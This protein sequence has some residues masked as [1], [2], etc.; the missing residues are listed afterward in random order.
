MLVELILGAIVEEGFSAGIKHG[1]G[2][3]V[4]REAKQELAQIK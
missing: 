4:K 3:L 2:I 1:K